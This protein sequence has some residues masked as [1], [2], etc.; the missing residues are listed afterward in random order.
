[1]RRSLARAFRRASGGQGDRGHDGSGK[2]RRSERER[3]L[4][5]EVL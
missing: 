2:K 3:L 4:W 1:M 5:V